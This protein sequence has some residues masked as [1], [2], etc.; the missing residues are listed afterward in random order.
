MKMEVTEREVWF[1]CVRR[2]SEW[3]P[4]FGIHCWN[5]DKISPH[6]SSC[7]PDKRR[8]SSVWDEYFPAR[9]AAGRGGALFISAQPGHS[10]TLP[11][12][13]R[14][15]HGERGGRTVSQSVHE[16]RG[17]LLSVYIRSRCPEA[18]EIKGRSAGRHDELNKSNIVCCH[19]SNVVVCNY[20]YWWKKHVFSPGRATQGKGGQLLNRKML[21]YCSI[22]PEIEH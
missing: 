21:W 20:C 1:L 17:I 5:Q 14:C 6:M 19:V 8:P 10:N 3:W 4:A 18:E 15:V 12:E 2:G 16:G 13:V 7:Q 9:K 11:A 22:V